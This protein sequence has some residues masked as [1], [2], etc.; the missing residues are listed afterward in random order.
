MSRQLNASGT[1]QG[2]DEYRSSGCYELAGLQDTTQARGKQESESGLDIGVFR[3]LI[4]EQQGDYPGP[5]SIGVATFGQ[6]KG[7]SSCIV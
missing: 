2:Y 7:E 6:C 1:V 5:W 3:R 4:N